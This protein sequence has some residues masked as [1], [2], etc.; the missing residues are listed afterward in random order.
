ME[1]MFFST[2]KERDAAS[3]GS[4]EWNACDRAALKYLWWM[5]GVPS[6]KW[7]L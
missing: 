3:A 5:L 1:R 7:S 6:N 4:A 2:M